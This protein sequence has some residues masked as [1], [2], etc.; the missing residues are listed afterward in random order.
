M[1]LAGLACKILIRNEAEGK[2]NTAWEK[3]LRSRGDL[4]VKVIQFTND[5][6]EDIANRAELLGAAK[7]ENDDSDAYSVIKTD[8]TDWVER[9]LEAQLLDHRQAAQEAAELEAVAGCPVAVALS[10]GS[11]SAAGS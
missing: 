10:G 8:C 11:A 6:S 3:E 4:H 5:F 9:I 7:P 1:T 2:K